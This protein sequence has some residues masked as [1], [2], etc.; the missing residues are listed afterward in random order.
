MAVDLLA[1]YQALARLSDRQLAALEDENLEAFFELTDEREAAFQALQALE[2]QLAGLT[3]AERQA[4]AGLIPAILTAD[5]RIEA[6]L[7]RL[8]SQA[9][10]ELGT[11][12]T[13]MS[14]LQSYAPSAGK[15][16]YFIDRNS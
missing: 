2:P 13:G 5:E 6:Q 12:Q 7:D 4:I 3:P 16:A 1:A 11:L 15:E 9:R 10:S 14:A 8:A